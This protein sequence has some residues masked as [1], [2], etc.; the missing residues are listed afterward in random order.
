MNRILIQEGL[1]FYNILP[2]T[3][4]LTNNI[5]PSHYGGGGS[6]MKPKMKPK[7]SVAEMLKEADKHHS[8]KHMGLMRD[9]IKMG[10]TFSKA[11]QLANKYV[12]K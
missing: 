4:F 11:H 10:A 7:M 8:K 3:F 5:M 2:R 12:G 6:S 9:L 1:H